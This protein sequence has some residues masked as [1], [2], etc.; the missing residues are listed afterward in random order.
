MTRKTL[1]RLALLIL[2]SSCLH[3]CLSIR[4]GDLL[5]HVSYTENA[6][7]D[8]TP[9]MIDH[10]AIYAGWGRVIEAVPDKGVSV[11]WLDAL[12]LRSP[13]GYLQ[14]RVKSVDGRRSI[15]IARSYLD[16][17]YDTL[18]LPGND[19]IYCSELVQL[20]L[21]D[22]HGRSLLG[23][24]PMTFRDSTGRIPAFWLQRYARNHLGVPEG[25]PGTNPSEM[26]QRHNV[27]IIRAL[28]R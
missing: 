24:V 11:T 26:S 9:G 16:Q 28:H 15:Q 21:V 6:I 4:R 5:F 18:F 12:R 20:S 10:V 2:L 14:A 3:S 27:R 1:L 22:K 7:T 19:A 25:L 13:G 17:P 23:T 8:V